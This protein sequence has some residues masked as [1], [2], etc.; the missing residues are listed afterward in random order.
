M[1]GNAILTENQQP[2]ILFIIT[3]I[4]IIIVLF[5]DYFVVQLFCYLN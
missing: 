5:L 2:N 3:A 4:M 1:H